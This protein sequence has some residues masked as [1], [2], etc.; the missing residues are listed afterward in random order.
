[1]AHVQEKVLVTGA[2]GFSGLHV[3]D[4]LLKQGYTVRATARSQAKADSI[5]TTFP[6]YKDK[7][8]LAV[9]DLS[10]ENAFSGVLNGLSGV[11][12]VASPFTLSNIK[13]NL[14]ELINP[15]IN[16]VVSLLQEAAKVPTI[17]RIVITASFACIVNLSNAN[18]YVYSEKDYN[19]ITL[20]QAIAGDATTAY[21]ASKRLAE[22]AA[23][24]FVEK[25]KPHFDIVT[26]CPPMI[27]GPLVRNTGEYSESSAMFY[28][29]LTGKQEIEPYPF[30][31]YI[32]VRDLAQA[33]L[34]AYQKPE[35]SNQRFLP[36]NGNYCWQEVVDYAHEH[37][38]GQIKAK[39]GNPGHFPEVVGRADNSKSRTILGL[40]Y[41]PKEQTFHDTISQFLSFEQK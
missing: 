2:N 13:S 32:D 12:H 27:Y 21:I 30:D 23:F 3:V 41:R 19:P 5:L 24:D 8:E 6:Q 34:L 28:N 1:M 17:K 11:F 25:N 15:A 26:L 22:K 39:K 14:D 35:A 20:E 16:G 4:L 37:F 36:T 40:T 33:H 7:I 9:V 29:I 10:K 38:P 31:M 18:G